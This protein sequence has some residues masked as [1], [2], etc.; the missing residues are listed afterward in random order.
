[1]HLQEAEPEWAR[2]VKVQLYCTF[3]FL[4]GERK[5]SREAIS[6]HLHRQWF[7]QLLLDG[8]GLVKQMS[9]QGIA[10]MLPINTSPEGLLVLKYVLGATGYLQ[11]GE[12]LIQVNAQQKQRCKAKDSPFTK[13]IVS[14][15]SKN[16]NTTRY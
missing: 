12:T 2:H 16:K 3:I 13:A 14:G 11:M 5:Q 4:S 8:G 9:W 7:P 1:M 10:E 15:G 6:G